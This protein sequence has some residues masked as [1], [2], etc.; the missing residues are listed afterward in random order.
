MVRVDE[1]VGAGGAVIAAAAKAAPDKVASLKLLAP[2]RL[3]RAGRRG[4]PARV[5]RRDVPAGLKPLLGRLFADESLVTR[6]LVDDLLRYEQL[7]G[8]DKALGTL[9]TDAN[10]PADIVRATSADAPGRPRKPSWVAM[11]RSSRLAQCS[12]TC[13]RPLGT[14]ATA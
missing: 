1:A 12:T 2:R 5:R 6:Q 14:S 3:R 11:P 7:D 10:T 13:P 8:V 9:L 4:V